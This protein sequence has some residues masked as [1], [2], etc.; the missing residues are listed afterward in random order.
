MEKRI[1]KLGLWCLWF[2][3][4]HLVRERSNR[5]FKR[6]EESISKLKSSAYLFGMVGSSMDLTLS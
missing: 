2:D 4:D 6:I 3:V 1:T 5:T